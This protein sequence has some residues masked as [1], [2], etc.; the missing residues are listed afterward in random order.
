MALTVACPNC[1][2]RPHTEFTFGGELRPIGVTDP[3]EDFAHVYLSENAAG[4]QR[5]RWFHAMGC[6]RWVTLT[7]DTR[8][9]EVT[10]P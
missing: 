7:R 6:K 4:L 10:A 1:G 3:E 9:N 8:T 2:P 5:E